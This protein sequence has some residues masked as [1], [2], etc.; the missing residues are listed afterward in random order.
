MK[1]ILSTETL[2]AP[3]KST[4]KMKDLYNVSIYTALL[5]LAK[6][7]LQDEELQFVLN[8]VPSHSWAPASTSMLKEAEDFGFLISTLFYSTP[9]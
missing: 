5:T 8:T 9:S 7:L 1:S 3:R 2:L 4:R 6:G